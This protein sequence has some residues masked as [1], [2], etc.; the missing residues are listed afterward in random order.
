M[1]LH[2]AAARSKMTFVDA[3]NIKNNKSYF[4]Q[5]IVFCVLIK[6]L[7]KRQDVMLKSLSRTV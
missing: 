4:L 1:A 6:L 7:K 2:T 5:T 3:I